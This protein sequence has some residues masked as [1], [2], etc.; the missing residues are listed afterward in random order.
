[1]NFDPS[2]KKEEE[3]QKR[4]LDEGKASG[5]EGHNEEVVGCLSPKSV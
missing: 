3:R 5:T 1:M 4:S 2:K